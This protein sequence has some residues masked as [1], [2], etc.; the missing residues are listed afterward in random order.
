MAY[1]AKRSKKVIEEFELV[2]ENGQVVEQFDVE[3]DAG[4]T[5]EKLR[6]KH[7]ALL[8]AQADVAHISAAIGDKKELGNAYEKLGYAVSDIIEAVFGETSARKILEFYES[9][10]VEMAKEVLPFILNVVIPKLE[11]VAKE[12]KKQ[13]LSNYNRKVRR[14]VLKKMR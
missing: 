10:Y 8:R 12:N 4:A 2:N 13:I 6:K 11:E 5:V 1:Q 9:N 14:T 7:I 3:L